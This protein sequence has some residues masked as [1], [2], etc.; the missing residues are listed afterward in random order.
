MTADGGEF[1][2]LFSL[3]YR[4]YQREDIRSKYID[5]FNIYHLHT[6]LHDKVFN[7]CRSNLT[8][9]TFSYTSKL[10]EIIRYQNKSICMLH[11][12]PSQRKF[13]SLLASTTAFFF[14]D[15]SPK[16]TALDEN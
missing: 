9:M 16:V 2:K 15:H 7:V 13:I 5:D 10:P 3:R 6:T 14:V 11:T 12:E 8:R 4:I 1:L